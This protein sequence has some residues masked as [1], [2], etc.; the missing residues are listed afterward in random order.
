MKRNLFLYAILCLAAICAGVENAS[1]INVGDPFPPFSR[2]NILT[3]QECSYLRIP[4]DREFSLS[5][6]THDI[7]II[8]F[9]NVYCHTCRMQVEIFN[10]LF[11]AIQKDPELSSRVCMLGIAVGNSLEEIQDFRKNFGVL[12]PILSDRDKAIFNTT[13]NV[14]GTPH[15]YILRKEEQRFIIDYHAGGVTSKDRYLNTVRFALRGSFAG[16]TPGNRAPAFA[17]KTARGIIDGKKLQ[18]KK[19]LLYFPSGKRYPVAND[20]R[21]RKNQIKILMDIKKQFP[22]VPVLIVQ[23]KGF[24]LPKVLTAEGFYAGDPV[25]AKAMAQFRAKEGPTVYFINEYGRIAFKDEGITLYNAQAII[26]GKGEY[27]AV[28]EAKEED[29]LKLIRTHVEKDGKKSAAVEKEVLD[30]GNAV[31]VI[32]L[33]PRRDGIFLFARLESRPSLCDVCHDSHFFYVLDQDGV[34]RD[35]FF[36]QLTKL[37]NIPWT[38]EDVTKIKNQIIGKNIFGDFPFDPKADAVT[39][40]TMSSSLLYESLNAGKQV[41]AELKTYK[42]RYEHWKE[43]CVNN[44]CAVRAK[45]ADMKHRQPDLLVD[46]ALLQSTAKE[47]KATCPLD[48]TYLFLDNTI[49]CSNHGMVPDI[50][51]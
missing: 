7:I 48:G 45:L 42:F 15:T 31:Y 36:L 14:Q 9:L 38:D 35:F 28:P 11:T 4:P 27:K 8:E 22:E 32:A 34:I 24:A 18:G 51:K 23:Y 3:P 26:Q 39:T 13:G 2:E 40:A 25:D 21:N 43:V 6:L 30:N 33:E 41:F 20:T 17:I 37:G 5:E 46:D 16:T 12:Y 47:I 10:E 19:C 1:A 50:C 49:M 44:M 29:I